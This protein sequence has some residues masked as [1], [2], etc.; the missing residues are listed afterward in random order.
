M[1]RQRPTLCMV[2]ALRQPCLSKR[3]ASWVSAWFHCTR[4]PRP[5]L[6]R[7]TS[8]PSAVDWHYWTRSAPTCCN[9]I[10]TTTNPPMLGWRCPVWLAKAGCCTSIPPVSG[11]QYLKQQVVMGCTSGAASRLPTPGWPCLT[12]LV[13]VG[14][15]TS[16]LSTANWRR[17][18]TVPPATCQSHRAL[19]PAALRR[20]LTVLAANGRGTSS[21]KTAGPRRHVPPPAAGHGMS[22]PPTTSE[23]THRTCSNRATFKQA[24]P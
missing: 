14:C 23:G 7:G 24:R 3:A 18:H 1:G 11:W 9:M 17:C 10:S 6:S 8:T 12:W 13:A 19:P 2:T 5:G 4:L 21:L 16:A 22:C 20:R 15:S